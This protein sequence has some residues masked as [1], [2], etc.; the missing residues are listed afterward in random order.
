MPAPSKTTGPWRQPRPPLHPLIP[1]VV[2]QRQRC[3]DLL[4]GRSLN[5]FSAAL[6]VLTGAGHGIASGGYGRNQKQS[7]EQEFVLHD[8][9]LGQASTG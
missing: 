5:F 7:Y 3:N 9:S 1:Y 2:D 4:L 6:N 8:I